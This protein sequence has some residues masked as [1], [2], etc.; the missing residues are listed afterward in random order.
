VKIDRRRFTKSLAAA[1]GMLALPSWSTKAEAARLPVNRVTKIRTEAD[2]GKWSAGFPSKQHD[3]CSSI[4]KPALPT[5]D[6]AIAPP[7]QR[8]GAKRRGGGSGSTRRI[9]RSRTTTPSASYRKLRDIF[10]VSR[11]PLLARRGDCPI[12]AYQPGMLVRLP[13][14]L[15][16]QF[17]FFNSFALIL[18][19]SQ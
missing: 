4:P 8:G 9:C 6:E 14:H 11:P 17:Q 18:R 2:V 19:A 12:H 10:L 15:P 13:S 3:R 16:L 1:A 7:G 5:D